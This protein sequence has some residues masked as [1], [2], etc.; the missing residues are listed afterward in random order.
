LP[1]PFARAPPIRLRI[2][3]EQLTPTALRQANG[4][5]FAGPRELLKGEFF[6]RNLLRYDCQRTAKEQK[7]KADQSVLF[8]ENA[9]L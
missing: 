4:F 6:S 1:P 7:G 2:N 5:G 8:D 3:V 9:P